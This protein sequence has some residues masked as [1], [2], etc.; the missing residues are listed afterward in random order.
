M[1]IWKPYEDL[2]GHPPDFRVTY[3]FYA[4]SE[5]RITRPAY[6]GLRSDFLYDGDDI[7]KIGIFCIHT[8]FEDMSG[9]V[10]MDKHLPVPTQGTAT[11]WILFPEMRRLVHVNRIKTGIKGYFMAGG[12]RLGEV[13]VTEVL[14]LHKNAE[15]LR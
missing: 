8:Q 12:T 15:T 1:S 14:G 7:K 6:Q 11:M 9:N 10:I 4:E 3:R 13:E 5:G 2:K